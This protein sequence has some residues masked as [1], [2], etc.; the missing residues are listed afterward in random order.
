MTK[1]LRSG[2]KVDAQKYYHLLDWKD[3]NMESFQLFREYN[4]IEAESIN[5]FSSLEYNF[6]LGYS[7]IA[8][9]KD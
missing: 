9:L 8:Y 1:E 5:D 2:I 4:G 3:K 7:K 6:L